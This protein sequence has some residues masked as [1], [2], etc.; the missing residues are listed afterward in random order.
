MS[1]SPWFFDLPAS[2]S[3]MSS[4]IP[5]RK[6]YT[7]PI[8][9]VVPDPHDNKGIL[10]VNPMTSSVSP[11]PSR[12]NILCSRL[13]SPESLFARVNGS[14]STSS[15]S[16][17]RSDS[18]PVGRQAFHEKRS[19]HAS[20]TN[21]FPTQPRSRSVLEEPYSPIFDRKRIESKTTA[22]RPHSS[23]SPLPATQIIRKSSLDHGR[24]FMRTRSPLRDRYAWSSLSMGGNDDKFVR[25]SREKRQTDS[26]T[27]NKSRDGSKDGLRDKISKTRDQASG[28]RRSKE[29]MASRGYDRKSSSKDDWK[30]HPIKD[31]AINPSKLP[32]SPQSPRRKSHF[33]I[34]N[35]ISQKHARDETTSISSTT[36]IRGPL[37][38]NLVTRAVST[39]SVTIKKNSPSIDSLV[40]SPSPVNGK[41][42]PPCPV[43]GPVVTTAKSSFPQSRHRH[44]VIQTH[45]GFPDKRLREKISGDNK[46]KPF[47][48]DKKSPAPPVDIPMK[49]SQEYKSPLKKSISHR[50]ATDFGLPFMTSPIMALSA[51]S[52]EP[53]IPPLTV[54]QEASTMVPPK[55]VTPK[56]SPDMRETLAIPLLKDTQHGKVSSAL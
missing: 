50:E 12:D 32:R 6:G 17:H 37:A 56:K 4:P 18:S 49:S 5:V 8:F 30:N 2:R 9:S 14:H 3:L 55:I 26:K 25:L 54:R 24:S 42:Q 11:T 20:S 45:M 51:V 46:I 39:T 21:L 23:A 16:L 22:S 53:P 15:P 7:S 1:S 43:H 52:F 27:G 47:Y 48:I 38:G 35:K 40:K 28:K 36:T 19:R 13:K 29:N 44:N 34:L 10:T 31:T 41:K 33:G